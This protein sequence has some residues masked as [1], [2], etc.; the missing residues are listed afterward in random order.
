MTVETSQGNYPDMVAIV[1][2]THALRHNLDMI[3]V[4]L[5]EA[6]ADREEV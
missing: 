1:E 6:R 4:G 5:I 2:K 3:L